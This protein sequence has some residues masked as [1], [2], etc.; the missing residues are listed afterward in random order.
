MSCEKTKIR[1]NIKKSL[2]LFF[3]KV[4]KMKIKNQIIPINENDSVKT[5]FPYLCKGFKGRHIIMN[6]KN[7][8]YLEKLKTL[9]ISFTKKSELTNHKKI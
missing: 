7:V 9:D 8:T 1:V 2:R 4:R 6:R 3:S 5:E